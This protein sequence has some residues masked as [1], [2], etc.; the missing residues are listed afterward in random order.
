MTDAISRAVASPPEW[1][2][3]SRSPMLPGLRRRQLAP[4]DV[5]APSLAATKPAATALVIP[6]ILTGFVGRGA[7]LSV[8]IGVVAALLLRHVITEFTSRMVTSGSLYTFVVRA[9]G[10]WAGLVTAVSMIVGYG[11]A[12]G[13]AL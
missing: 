2:E 10:S 11:F 6:I 7:W 12:C 5:L 4:L 1:T 8:V 13:Y 9:L 3:V